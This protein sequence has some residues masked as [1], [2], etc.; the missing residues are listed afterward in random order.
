[1][2]PVRTIGGGEI[3]DP[4]P[5]N[6]SAPLSATIAQAPSGE[7]AVALVG[8]R[9]H[10]V[11]AQF[12]PILL[13]R[14]PAEAGRLAET[15]ARLTRVAGHLVLTETLSSLAGRAA[16]AVAAFH[17]S[18]PAE[19]GIPLETLRQGL[20]V[21]EWLADAAVTRAAAD[22]AIA[23]R[24]GSVAAR[25]FRPSGAGGVVEVDAVVA[26]LVAAGLTPPAVAE[27]AVRLGRPGVAASLRAAAAAGRA[28]AVE[29][30]RY[31]A[32]SVLDD[33]VRVLG[34]IG[35]EGEFSVGAVRDRTG[36]SRKFLIPLLEW[37]DARGW[38][39]RRGD[40]REFRGGHAGA[41]PSDPAAAGP[42]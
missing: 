11:P 21:P 7:R 38:T 20:R 12:L 36:L 37:S 19:R 3:I 8:R 2:S 35:A 29:R 23:H 39:A 34:E 18:H 10:G 31:Y 26:A 32:Q 9:R 14:P 30:D 22:G 15:D 40:L 1:M 16:A 28:E 4:A 24:D 33:F 27:L 6:R 42:A 13:G 17:G 41:T 25:D 5:P